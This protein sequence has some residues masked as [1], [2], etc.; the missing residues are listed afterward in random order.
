MKTTMITLFMILGLTTFLFAQEKKQEVILMGAMHT[1]PK[2][3]KNSY[4]PMLRYA[5]KYNPQAIYVENP[6][7]NDTISWN[8][9]K[10]GWSKGYKRFYQLS[11]SLK[12]SFAFDSHKFETIL[13]KDHDSMTQSDLNYLMNSFGY[14][15]D[16]GNYELYKYIKIHGVK[17]SKKPTRNENGDLTFKL[18]ISLG[19]KMIY[20]MDDQQTNGEYHKAWSQCVREGRSNGNNKANSK[21]YNKDY[22][23]AILPAVFRGLGR[24]TNT[25]KSIKRLH[26][27]AAFNYVLTDTP[28]CK[29]GRNY[30]HQRD[31]RMAKNIAKQILATQNERSIVIVGAAHIVGLERELKENYPSLKV[32]LAYE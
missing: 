10:N 20:N 3:V 6:M 24:H 15:R 1:V 17:G 32:R 19:H 27:M 14:T 2:I 25:R 29:K 12:K 8:Y 31:M 9:L 16:I 13:A 21:L 22:N 4:K 23:S 7:S 30:F 26:D 28:G 11:D 18:A 5:R